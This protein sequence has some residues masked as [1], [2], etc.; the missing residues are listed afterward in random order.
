MVSRAWRNAIDSTPSLWNAVV[1]AVPFHVNS[2]S[3]Q[4]SG[5]CPLDVYLTNGTFRSR[6]AKKQDHIELLKLA[7]GEIRRWSTVALRLSSSDVCTLYLTSPAPRL[8]NLTVIS[9]I[10]GDY[11]TPVTLFGGIA[12]RLETL[13]VERVPIDWNSPFI[14]GLRELE[15]SDMIDEQISTQQVLDILSSAPLLKRLSIWKSFLEDHPQP[16][17]MQSPIIQLPNL[18]TIYFE[19]IEIKAVEIILSSIRAPNCRSLTILDWQDEHIHPSGFLERALGHFCDF[20]RQTL[21]ANNNSSM[22]SSNDSMQ[23][24]SCKRPKSP[25][26]LEFALDL[27]C[28][29][30]ATGV[31]WATG[32]IGLGAQEV[33]HNLEVSLAHER[34]NEGDLAAYR[35]FSRCR[36]V[37]KLV[38]GDDYTLAGPILELLGTWQEPVDGIYSL[39]AFPSLKFLIL[40]TS[41][42]WTLDDLEVLVSRRFGEPGDTATAKIPTLSIVIQSSWFY[43]SC[44]G[45]KPDLAQ[46]QRLRGSKGVESLTRYMHQHEPGMLGVVYEDDTEV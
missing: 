33:E 34:L 39:P 24:E 27:R 21:S 43:E 26:S 37:T 19:D 32:V 22:H 8:R 15:L 40:V 29:A 1:D 46:L 31:G 28:E 7:A 11:T 25:G 38:L 10:W 5:S 44:P 42:E 3:V 9:G 14:H 4:R 13:E 17:R 35:S 6:P 16:F 2:T 45:S 36:S 23:W 30:L 12:P 41:E 20:L 18:N